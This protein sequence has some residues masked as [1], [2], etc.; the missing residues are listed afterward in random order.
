MRMCDVPPV[1][2][3]RRPD[4][5]HYDPSTLQLPKDFPKA[6]AAQRSAA[7]RGSAAL[8]LQQ[9]SAAALMSLRVV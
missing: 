2:A 1:C 3:G 6:R 4:D 5:A 7:Q 8:A 9:A